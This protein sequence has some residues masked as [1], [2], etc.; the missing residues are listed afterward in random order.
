M[1]I[2]GNELGRLKVYGSTAPSTAQIPMYDTATGEASSLTV[3]E[4]VSAVEVAG[5]ASATDNAI[6]RFDL[7]TGK[8]IQDSVVTIADTTG[9][10]AGVGA[11]A[12]GG[13]LTGATTITASSTV[14]GTDLVATSFTAASSS[15]TLGNKGIATLGGSSV[16]TMF[17]QPPTVGCFKWLRSLSTLAHTVTSSAAFIGTTAAT[18]ITFSGPTG[19]VL[20]GESSIQWGIYGRDS[21]AYATS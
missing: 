14:Q 12:I 11:L 1:M 5:P 18:V 15:Q 16:L 13:A 19:L 4:I 21:T 10:M 3:T 6:A 8:I 17:L 2:I 9:D 7:T 20:R